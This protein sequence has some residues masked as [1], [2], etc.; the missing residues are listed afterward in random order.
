MRVQRGDVLIM[1][2]LGLLSYYLGIEVT[3]GPGGIT[4][5]QRAYA[6][7]LLE[8]SGMR[9][10]N[11][12]IAPMDATEYRRIIGG[13]RYHIHTRPN[14][15]FAVGFQSRFMEAPHEEHQAAVK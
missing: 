5:C 9:D 14:L 2:G 1:S 7:K 4:L 12:T 8:C 15:P 3:Q 6:D 13:L 11:A 10:Y